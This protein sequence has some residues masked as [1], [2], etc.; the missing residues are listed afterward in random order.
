MMHRQIFKKIHYPLS[1][2][3]NYDIR[4]IAESH[5]QKIDKEFL[6]FGDVEIEKQNFIAP[7]IINQYK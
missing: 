7:P 2:Q 4:K 5:I 1:C 6:E 3:K